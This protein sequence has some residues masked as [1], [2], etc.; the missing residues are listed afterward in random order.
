MEIYLHIVYFQIFIHISVTIIIKN[1][2][3][4]IVKY[5]YE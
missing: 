2:Y 1:H 3:T 4:L 5:I